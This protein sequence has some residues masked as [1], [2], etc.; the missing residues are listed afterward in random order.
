MAII[1]I[2]VNLDNDIVKDLIDIY[3]RDNMSNATYELFKQ[4]NNGFMIA[5]AKALRNEA[6]T[7]AMLLGMKNDNLSE[8]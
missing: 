2:E 7:E 1:D 3:I 8:T 5:A 4:D 6:I